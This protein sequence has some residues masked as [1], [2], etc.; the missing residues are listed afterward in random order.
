MTTRND[1]LED[2]HER[3]AAYRYVDGV[4]FAFHGP[5]GA[6]TLSTMGHDDLVAGWV[7]AYKARNQPLDAPP[8]GEDIVA[9]DE[10]SWRSALGDPSR[11][12]DWEVL[13][14]RQLREHP[15]PAVVGR[16]VPHLLPGY[17]GALT[18]GIIRTAHAVR[19]L[20]AEGPPSDLLLRELGRGLAYWAATYLRLPG[21][22]E[23]RGRLTLDE[24]L[25]ALPRPEQA[26][27]PI[28]AGTFARLGELAR[29]AGAVEALG[30]PESLDD[31][32][33]DL[34][35]ASCR[36][37]LDNPGVV[38]VGPIHA[39][40]PTAAARVL[41][42]YLPDVSVATLYAQLWHVNA[43]I[44]AGFTPAPASTAPA[45]GD[46]APV[47][48]VAELV[49]RAVE[50]RDT[51]VVKFTEACV[52]EHARRPDPVYLRAAQRVIEQMPPW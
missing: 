17:A 48:G 1:A 51:H 10:A 52:R 20:P 44:A 6:E 39:V 32:L 23:L 49:A 12:S 4:G 3:L 8:T 26:W 47:A 25:R 43:A 41:L 15:W 29:F 2:A 19:A 42:P 11:V 40:T 31:A 16:W 38:P 13:F 50:H 22:P 14:A 34:T 35:A 37:L 27:S 36:L 5:M 18:H 9:G 33:S 28:E 7:E 30:P 24:A 45:D 21:R 46:D